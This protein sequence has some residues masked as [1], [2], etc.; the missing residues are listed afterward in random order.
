MTLTITNIDLSALALISSHLIPDE[1]ERPATMRKRHVFR[2]ES[3][4]PLESRLALSG[5]AI[6]ATAAVAQVTPSIRAKSYAPGDRDTRTFEI[7]FLAGM[8]PHHKMAIEM[9]RLALRYATDSQVRNLARRIISAQTPE[10]RRMNRYLA[11]DGVTKYR[12]GKAPDE[13]SDLNMLGS[14]RGVAFDRSFL[15]MMLEHHSMAIEGDEMGMVGAKEAQTRAA[16]EGIRTL[17][18][19]IVATQTREIMEMQ[20][21]L[22][23]LGNSNAMAAG[24]NHVM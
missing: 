12:P 4:G 15:T 8:I 6:N 2:P 7:N 14:Q 17:A 16:Q 20:G 19:N 11:V 21:I 10:I 13:I 5:A 9:S 24:R 1:P 22:A 18:G 23:R 3:L